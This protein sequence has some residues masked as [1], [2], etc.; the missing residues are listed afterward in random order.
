ML[1]NIYLCSLQYRL[2][3]F[4]IISALCPANLLPRPLF[5][6]LFFKAPVNQKGNQCLLW[7][8]GF[9]RFA[10]WEVLR[11]ARH[12]EG[13]GCFSTFFFSF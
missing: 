10:Q 1:Y 5:F 7:V 4:V 9:S 6:S 12:D 3:T 13:S 11:E 2:L 8:T